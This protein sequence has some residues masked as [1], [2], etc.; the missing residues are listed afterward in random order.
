M[1]QLMEGV[2]N[3][4]VELEEFFALFEQASE[5]K[6]NMTEGELFETLKALDLT[7]TETLDPEAFK[8]ML[9]TTGDQTP[10]QDVDAILDG[11]PRNR[12]GRVSCRLIAR[13]LVGGPDG[14]Q[15]I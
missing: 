5:Q 4:G 11:L 7:G 6:K 15:H 1:E 14:I 10:A 3:V 8:D 9:T 13:R 12:L 2:E